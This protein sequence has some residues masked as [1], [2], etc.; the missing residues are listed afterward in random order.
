VKKTLNFKWG[1]R[2]A[3]WKG[4][5]VRTPLQYIG[6]M[7]GTEKL[8]WCGY[9][10]VKKVWCRFYCELQTIFGH[11]SEN[12]ETSIF[13]ALFTKLHLSTNGIISLI[14]YRC[15][16]PIRNGRLCLYCTARDVVTV[17]RPQHWSRGSQVTGGSRP[18]NGQTREIHGAVRGESKRPTEWASLTHTLLCAMSW[19][20][21]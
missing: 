17:C 19:K 13:L 18:R 10:M 14:W 21:E 16:V 20:S 12:M 2:D 1:S 9:P 7:F 4:T 3:P 6:I 11:I 5:S 15:K 8:D